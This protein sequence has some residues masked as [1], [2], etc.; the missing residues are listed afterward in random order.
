MNAHTAVDQDLVDMMDAV[1]ARHRE[2][3]EPGAEWDQTLWA[4]LGELGLTRLT[5][6]EDAGGSGAGWFEAAELLRAAVSHA[7]R[8]P[9]AEHDLL[10]GWLLDVAG[11]PVDNAR[12]TVCV[13]DDN[14]VARDVPWADE[15]DRIVVVWRADNAYLVGDV[16]PS[17]LRIVNGANLAGEPR[18]TVST[19]VGTLTGSR[20][21]DTVFEQLHLRGALVRALQICAAL[22]AIL[23]LSI[24]HA[25][26]RTQFGRPLA[27]F[28]AVQNLVADIAGEA[29]LARAATE[30]ALAAAVRA[31]WSGANVEFLVAVARS[32]AGHA[33][34]VVVRNAHQIHGAIGTTQEHRLHE[35]TKPALAWRSE[36]GS[37]HFWDDKLTEAASTAGRDNLWDLV[38]G[39][40]T[41][42]TT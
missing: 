37:T 3:Y 19:D 15:A 4:R 41:E 40:P 29:A 32:C 34:S 13:L 28:Q 33:A 22:D 7:V 42:R 10:A 38:T 25:T 2:Q 11:L 9:I 24:T 16:A 12:R 1:F 21:S 27:K 26:D 39:L 8:V 17:D 18:G 6:R 31:G 35:Y 20:V 14:G 36:F 23:E 5:G 30:A